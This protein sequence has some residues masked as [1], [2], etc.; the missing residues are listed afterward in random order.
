MMWTRIDRIADAPTEG[1][2]EGKIASPDL[3]NTSE[4][5]WLITRDDG[6]PIIIAGLYRH[7]MLFTDRLVWFIP[8][9]ALRA[10]DWRGIRRLFA[11][12]IEGVDSLTAVVDSGNAAA[13]RVVEHLNFTLVL[14]G[15]E[16][17]YKWQ[18]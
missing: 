14:D 7:S 6:T 1:L 4:W 17:V 8:Y 11:K 18:S 12:L 5:M 13:V 16:R 2:G 10:A 3:L 15:P 9:A